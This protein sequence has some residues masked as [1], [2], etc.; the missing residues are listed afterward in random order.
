M[1]ALADWI[2]ANP[3]YGYFLGI[4]FGIMIVD[5]FYSFKVVEKIRT[6]AKDKNIVVRYEELK[7]TIKARATALKQKHSFLLPFKTNRGLN[8][9][10]EEI[11]SEEH[12]Q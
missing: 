6:W 5:V 3:I 11:S 7:E 8:K 9:E 12:K 2:A 4:Y 1:A 10:L